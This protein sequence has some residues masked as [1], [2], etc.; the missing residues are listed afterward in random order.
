MGADMCLGICEEP[1]DWERAKEVIEYRLE[2]IS[3]EVVNDI[4][5]H[6]LCS[7]LEDAVSEKEQALSEDDLYEINDLSNKVSQ[8]LGRKRI[9][10]ALDEIFGDGYRRDVASIM[11]KDTYYIV[12]GGMSWGDSPTE[13]M[14]DI[15]I[16]AM[17]GVTD[18]LGSKDFDYQ[19][20]KA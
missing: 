3:S 19:S 11:L 14:A 2:N 6:Y 8:E 15:D 5:D 10:E 1:R 12:S 17:S 16:I 9:R 4:V 13:A 7:E 20:F 18:G